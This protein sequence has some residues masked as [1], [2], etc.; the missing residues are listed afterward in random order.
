MTFMFRRPWSSVLSA[1]C[2]AATIATTSLSAPP[3]VVIS[4]ARTGPPTHCTVE[5]MRNGW[6]ARMSSGIDLFSGWMPN[7][8]APAGFL[9]PKTVTVSPRLNGASIEWVFKNTGTT[10]AV[11]TDLELPQFVLGSSP[12]I[13]DATFLGAAASVS[14]YETPW[15][16][17]AYPRN[18]YSPITALKWSD[19][20]VGLSLI[21]PVLEYRHDATMV[22]RNLGGGRWQ[23]LIALSNAKVGGH[24]TTVL[25]YPASIPPGGEKR[26]TVELRANKGVDDWTETVE[27]YRQYFRNTYGAVQYTRDGRTIRAIQ[28]A[29]GDRQSSANP[30]GWITESGRPDLNGYSTV[31][32]LIRSSFNKAARTVV[33]TPTGLYKQNVDRNY[34]FRFTSRWTDP[35]A[36]VAMRNA[37]SVLSNI[38][39]QP[40]QSWGLWW[41]RAAHPQSR[42]D[43]GE[44]TPLKLSE[45]RTLKLAQIELDIAI[46]SGAKIIGLDAF[47]HSHSPIWELRPWLQQ[48]VSGNPGVVFCTEGRNPD[49]MHILAPT[50][51]DAF[52]TDKATRVNGT[53]LTSRFVFADWLLPG[54][55]TWAG[56]MW[57]R[58]D[59][60][61]LRTPSAGS[62]ARAKEVQRL[63]A[64]G[65]V[66]VLFGD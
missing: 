53:L 20:A 42:W 43:T 22:V 5:K 35:A 49:V 3:P 8:T 14:T 58:S 51:V 16:G 30:D 38:T 6:R 61:D 19:C 60:A 36:S 11:P 29:M 46:E 56:L 4:P 50:W 10:P 24:W 15:I 63:H 39:T 33:W 37:P 12:K 44:F 64:L 28:L 32:N 66:P 40:G 23:P 41:G 1:V 34:P 59:R 45:P 62:T 7:M 26:Y 17:G 57:N 31:A 21:Y 27:P 55:E 54:H 25:A 9:A 65:F 48:M 2:V 47:T 13:V 18:L 52:G